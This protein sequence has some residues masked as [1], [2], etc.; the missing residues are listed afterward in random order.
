[1][2]REESL[3][4]FV[5][6]ARWFGGKGR[7]FE[8]TG[9]T[10]TVL[11]DDVT[12]TLLTVSYADGGSDLYQVP[13]AS[14]DGPQERLTHALI[15]QWDDQ[16]HYDAVHDRETMQSWL[17]AFATATQQEPHGAFHRTAEHDLDLESH[18]T[19]FSGEQSNSSVAFGED[20]LMKLFRRVTPG[21]NPDIEILEA[22][23][24]AGNTH[25]AALYGYVDSDDLQLAMLQQFLRTASDGWELALVSARNLFAEGDLHADEVG[26]DFAGEA[27][28][29]GAAVAEVHQ[30]LAE[31]FPTQ[32]LVLSGIARDMRDRLTAALDV[33]P[34]L[35][36]PRPAL[37]ERFDAITAL[38]SEVSAQRIHGDLHLGQTLR[39]SLGW[40]LVDFEGEPA[41]SLEDRRLPDSPWRD[42][43]GMLRSF[44]YAAQSVVKDLHSGDEPSPQIA[45]RAQEWVARNRE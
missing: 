14:Y 45:Y 24:H 23:T 8:V 36:E 15:G 43:A 44:D 32:P 4:A 34:D 31:E 25:V 11:A 18:S 29:L 10:D 5:G 41:K 2:T 30:V 1:M 19:L 28:R 17:R 21:R 37:V 26:G 38:A 16:W 22:L 20:S 9:L 35:G 40:K 33:V 7:E 12:T 3:T 39:T 42:V 6:E 27:H 13:I